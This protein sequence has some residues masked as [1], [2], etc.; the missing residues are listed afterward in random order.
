MGLALERHQLARTW[1]EIA[2]QEPRV[3]LQGLKNRIRQMSGDFTMGYIN[4]TCRG[5]T[6]FFQGD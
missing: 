1:I 2:W 5:A 3:L 4:A 6:T